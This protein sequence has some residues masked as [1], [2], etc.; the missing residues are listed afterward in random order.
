MFEIFSNEKGKALTVK[1]IK[2]D[3]QKL[4][5]SSGMCR[6]NF[7]CQL[8]AVHDA[9][10]NGEDEVAMCFYISE[11]DPIIHFLN[12]DNEGKYVDNTLGIW[13]SRIE[14]YLVRKVSKVD[15]F[16]INNIFTEYRNQVRNS[17]PWH[18][19]TFSDCYF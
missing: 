2:R 3:L 13:S 14:Y 17:L 15:F 7:R 10:T 4:E 6:Y 18:I 12:I 19:R 9:I 8:N 11:G 16:N 5:V 1:M